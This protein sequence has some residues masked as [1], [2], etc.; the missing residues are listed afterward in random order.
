MLLKYIEENGYE[1]IWNKE[2]EQELL[3]EIRIS[4]M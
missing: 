3:T 2:T 4:V 1:I